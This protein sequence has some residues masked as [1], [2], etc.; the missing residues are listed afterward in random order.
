MFYYLLR[1]SDRD[2]HH[3][4]TS[5]CVHTFCFVS[6]C[7]VLWS[8]ALHSNSFETYWI[9]FKW[10]SLYLIMN[11]SGTNSGGT[12]MLSSST[13]Y[14]GN[15]GCIIIKALFSL[16]RRNLNLLIFKQTLGTL[17]ER[18]VGEN[19]KRCEN[20]LVFFLPFSLL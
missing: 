13:L 17:K 6:L 2:S 10:Q 19:E 8:C 20:L 12:K 14:N 7:C 4:D 5:L 18:I 3:Q 1:L 11:Y 9:P 15:N 16:Q